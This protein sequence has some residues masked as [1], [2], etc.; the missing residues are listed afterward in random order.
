MESALLPIGSVVL[1]KGGKKRLMIYG[2]LQKRNGDGE[3]FDYLGCYYP[4]GYINQEHA[5]LF[6]AEDIQDVSYV[7]FVDSE[8][9]IFDA[10][11]KEK[12]SELEP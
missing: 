8:Y 6:N 3:V 12:F 4:E 5:Y 10:K 1:L 11:L 9:Q 7:G 2:L